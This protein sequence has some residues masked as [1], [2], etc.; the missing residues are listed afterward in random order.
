MRLLV[1]LSLILNANLLYADEIKLGVGLAL[2]P[3]VIS[4]DNTGMELQIVQEAL[5][6]G[7]HHVKIV[8]LPF[9]RVPTSIAAREIDAAVTINENS[10][11]RNIYYSDIHMTY[12]N[13]AVSLVKNQFAIQSVSDLKDYSIIAF[14]NAKNYLGSDYA[15]M[16]IAN[17]RYKEIAQ[18]SRQIKML[19]SG[20]VEVIVLDIN[21]F[22][23]YK[24]REPSLDTSVDITIHELFPPSDY[25][26]GFLDE[27]IRKD[28]NAGL[29]ALKANGRYQEI[30]K[31]Y[32]E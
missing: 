5:A 15:E 32:L 19:Y 27:Q 28:F 22:K 24:N 21:I 14:Q 6:L 9:A 16:T 10:G 12:Q 7:G 31:S 11:I 30:I 20:R 29:K 25:K 3:Y 23:Y 8:H 1:L 4:E 2:P 26:V 17:G 13:V 18:Q